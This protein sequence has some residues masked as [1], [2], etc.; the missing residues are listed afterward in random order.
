MNHTYFAA[1][2]DTAAVAVLTWPG[3][4]H[5]PPGDAAAAGLLGDPVDGVQF[6]QELGRFADLVVDPAADLDL[7]DWEHRIAVTADER[8][9][10]IRVPPALVRTVADTDVERLHAVVP[11]WTTLEGFADPD[12]D[13]LRA[14]VTDLRGLCRTAVEAG[15]GVYCNGRA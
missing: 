13:R 15:G 12:P 9:V 7:E 1:R 4:V 10:I 5:R 14:F 11:A 2:S 3:G 8:H 6:S